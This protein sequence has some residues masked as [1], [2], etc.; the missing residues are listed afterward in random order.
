MDIKGIESKKKIDSVDVSDNKEDEY[1]EKKINPLNNIHKCLSSA[2]K[3]HFPSYFQK[4]N[5][6]PKISEDVPVYG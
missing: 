4:K 3:S 1:K 6:L 5:N 2:D